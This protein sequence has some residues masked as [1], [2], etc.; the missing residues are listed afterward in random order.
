[1]HASFVPR[2]GER[3]ASGSPD[4]AAIAAVVAVALCVSVTV[5]SVRTDVFRQFLAPLRPGRLLDLATGHGHFARIAHEIGWDVVAVDA[6]DERMPMTDGIEWRVSD[7]REFPVD[8]Y[9]V[10][11]NL[12]LMYH[13]DIESQVELYT[14]CAPTPMLLDTHHATRVE[15]TDGGYEGSWYREPGLTTSSWGNARSFWPTRPE[16]LRLLADCGYE[17]VWELLPSYLPDRTFYWC[18]PG[19]PTRGGD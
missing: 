7:V 11:S 15:G 9:D 6:R 14:R 16:L 4:R 19:P 17:S 8:G 18:A 3:Q 10:I 1:M 2:P 12:G 5:M 13:M